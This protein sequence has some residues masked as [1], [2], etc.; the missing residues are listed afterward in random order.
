M[1]Q[2]RVFVGPDG[3]IS[4]L[5]ELLVVDAPPELLAAETFRMGFIASNGAWTAT[6]EILGLSIGSFYT[7]P[8]A[9]IDSAA[10]S[11]SLPDAD[12]GVAYTGKIAV[13][14]LVPPALFTITS[15]AL[16]AGLV[17]DA[18]TGDVTGTPTAGAVSSWCTVTINDARVPSE[19]SSVTFL[20]TVTGT[21]AATVSP[22]AGAVVSSEVN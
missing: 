3:K 20:L 9:S 5:K 22:T 14:N 7:L 2:V 1:V 17:L 21:T 16:P 19:P 18:A 11:T 15:G 13:K 10:L 12:I 8:P 6:H 4:S